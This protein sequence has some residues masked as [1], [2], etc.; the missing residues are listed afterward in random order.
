MFNIFN[1]LYIIKQYSVEFLSFFKYNYIV[2]NL[3][4]TNNIVHII[5]FFHL[6]VFAHFFTVEL[7]CL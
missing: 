3:H 6:D 4:K 7:T 1:K 2:D 5:F